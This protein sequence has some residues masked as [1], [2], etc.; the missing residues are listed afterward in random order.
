MKYEDKKCPKCGETLAIIIYGLPVDI[1]DEDNEK[2]KIFLG[3]C[4]IFDPSPRYHCFNCRRGYY[5]D[6]EKYIEQENSME[7][8]YYKEKDYNIKDTNSN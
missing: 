5:E 7:D 2:K 8:H 3:G 6:L 1:D 4:V